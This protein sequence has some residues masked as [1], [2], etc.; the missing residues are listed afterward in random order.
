MALVSYENLILD[1]TS[2]TK[3][4]LYQ[5]SKLIFMGDG[6]KAI[7]QFIRLSGEA[8]EVM[9]RFRAQLEQREKPKF[10]RQGSED[11]RRQTLLE[12]EKRKSELRKKNPRR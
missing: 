10:D 3:A 12:E 1:S 11:L 8:P 5:D 2:S 7:L 9:E 6:Y 4:K